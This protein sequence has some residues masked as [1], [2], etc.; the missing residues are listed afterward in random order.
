MHAA[1]KWIDPGRLARPPI[2]ASLV[3][4][5]LAR[6]PHARWFVRLSLGGSL[7][8]RRDQGRII[9]PSP[10]AELRV[11]PRAGPWVSTR[12]RL[13]VGPRGRPWAVA[14]Q[15]CSLPCF[16]IAA[17]VR[18]SM[19]SIGGKCVG[20]PTVSIR[21]GFHVRWNM[22]LRAAVRH[23]P[24]R[25]RFYLGKNGSHTVHIRF[26]NGSQT[27]HKTVHTWKMRC[28]LKKTKL[29]NKKI[30]LFIFLLFLCISYNLAKTLC[31]PYVNRFVNR[32]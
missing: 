17:F 7:A 4:R 29:L 27:V 9:G 19:F 22:F 26:T 15:M 25:S 5:S 12:A 24:S 10:R 14:R 13:R 11:E 6:S 2:G 8:P 23:A 3:P 31:F 32:L 18:V 28:F 21:L 20:I 1:R 30:T 16:S